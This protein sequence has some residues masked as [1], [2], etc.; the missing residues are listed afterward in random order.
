[1]KLRTIFI[2]IA[3]TLALSACGSDGVQTG[4]VTQKEHKDPWVQ[5]IPQTICSGKPLTCKTSY[6]IIAHPESW[7]FKVQNDT[8]SGTVSVDAVTYAKYEVG[9]WYP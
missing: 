8:K 1:M 4:N 9:Q 5:T 2:A 3:A 7:K 6:I